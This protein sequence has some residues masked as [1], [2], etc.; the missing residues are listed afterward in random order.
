MTSFAI[1][2]GLEWPAI[3]VVGSSAALATAV[4]LRVIHPSVLTQV[5]VLT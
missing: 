1:L 5:G 4:A 2:A 3:G